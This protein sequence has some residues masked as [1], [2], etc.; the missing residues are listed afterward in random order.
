MP[1]ILFSACGSNER[2]DGAR[3]NS[4]PALNN[5]ITLS[6]IE[7]LSIGDGFYE[8]ESKLDQVCRMASI[9]ELTYLAAEGGAY[10]LIF[11]DQDDPDNEKRFGLLQV[12]AYVPYPP[13]EPYYILPENKT[14]QKFENAP[15]FWLPRDWRPPASRRSDTEVGGS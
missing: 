8:V 6:E 7:K 12:I 3:Q 5:S 11:Y 13:A 9:P 1:C 4:R 2:V 14:G 10:H 15:Y